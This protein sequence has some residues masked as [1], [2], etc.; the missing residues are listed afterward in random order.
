MRT[1]YLALAL[2]ALAVGACSLPND[3][4]LNGPSVTDYSN[5]TTMSQL[6]TLVT[7][8]LSNDRLPAEEQILEAEVIGRDAFVLTGSEFR[9]ESELLGPSIDPS[10]FLGV[11][12]WPFGTIRLT[13]IGLRGV[14]SSALLNAQDKA[15][16]LGYLQTMKALLFIRIVE[17]RDTAGAPIDVDIDPTLPPA[18]LHCRHDVEAYIAALL[19]SAATNL[20]AGGTT[21]P[22][23][24]PPTFAGFDTPA[25]F[26]KF[27]RGLAAKANVYLA[28]RGYAGTAAIDA[29]ALAAAQ[30][31]LNASFRDSTQSVELGPS[32]DYSTNTGDQTNSLFDTDTS[33]TT[34]VANPRVRNEAEAGDARVARKTALSSVRSVEGETS[35]I[36]FT[37]YLI[38]TAPTLIL[39][40]KE[41]LLLQAEVDWGLGNYAGALTWAHVVRVHDGGPGLAAD[42]TTAAAPG[43]LNEIL[44]E[45]RY[46]LVWQSGDRW[47]DARLFGK[48]NG[49][50]PPVGIGTELTYGPLNNMPIP[51]NEVN[52]RGGNLTKTCTLGAP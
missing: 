32:H 36:V 48:L 34:Y 17:T 13:N 27:N 25:G 26:L 9:Y 1:R 21:F 45:K 39:S 24:L 15:A 46:S 44:Y 4:N 7:G 18:P 41:L 29:T 47:V 30:A 5:I 50:N 37:L 43:V 35:N 22:F 31:A 28:F 33:A 19:D 12:V 52:A 49:S 38:P 23:V 3:P 2:T 51:Q 11:R 40:N 8:V 14:N 42:T 10:G 16:T 20:A 6:Q